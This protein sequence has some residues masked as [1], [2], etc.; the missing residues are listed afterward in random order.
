[1]ELDEIGERTR[2]ACTN[3]AQELLGLVPELL[4]VRVYGELRKGHTGGALRAASTIIPTQR[5]GNGRLS[6][7]GSTVAS[8]R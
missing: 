7:Q 8:R 5:V 4:Q 2:L 3:V 6:R 1:M